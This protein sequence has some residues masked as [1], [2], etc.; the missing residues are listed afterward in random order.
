MQL[1]YCRF[2]MKTHKIAVGP[3]DMGNSESSGP[4]SPKLL[5]NHC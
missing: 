4:I 5:M 3:I 1:W 2:V